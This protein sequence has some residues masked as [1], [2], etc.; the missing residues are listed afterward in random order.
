MKSK[1]TSFNLHFSRR[2]PRKPFDEL[3]N[4]SG[5]PANIGHDGRVQ[6]GIGCD[7]IG[8]VEGEEGGASHGVGRAG[9]ERAHGVGQ[10]GGD[11]DKR[12]VNEFSLVQL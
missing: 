12:N 11:T 7:V 10:A 1:M 9:G 5:R 6:K 3:A 2:R 4:V 8:L